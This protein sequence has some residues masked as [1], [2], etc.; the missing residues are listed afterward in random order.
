[1]GDVTEERR[2]I[3]FLLVQLATIEHEQNSDKIREL[4]KKYKIDVF[5]AKTR[6]RNK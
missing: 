1:L 4:R 5:D 3:E 2:D 6:Q